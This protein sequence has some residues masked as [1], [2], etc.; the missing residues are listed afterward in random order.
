VTRSNAS[1]STPAR[2][3]FL[4]ALLSAAQLM[5]IVDVTIVN[6]ALPAI[7]ADLDMPRPT[8]RGS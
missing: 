5:V 4:L 2:P 3:V 7:A 1:G 6:V 8:S